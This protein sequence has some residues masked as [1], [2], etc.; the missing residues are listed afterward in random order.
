MSDRYYAFGLTIDSPIRLPEAAAADDGVAVDVMVTIGGSDINVPDDRYFR[1]A[2]EKRSWWQVAP[3]ENRLVFNCPAGLYEIKDGREIRIQPYPDANEETLKIFLLGTAMGAAQI[4]R[5]R[6]PIHGGAI[7]TNRGAMIVTGGQGAGKST[8]TSAF[9]HNGY[10]YL[11]DD[12]SSVDIIDGQALIIPAYP[13]RK[14]V[15]DA[16]GP[17]GYD[18]EE[19]VIVDN[20]RDKFAIRDKD[21]WRREPLKLSLIIELFPVGEGDGVSAQ[22]I[23]GKDKLGHVAKSLYRG[24]MHAPSG[25]LA[26]QEFKKILT[27]AAQADICRVGVPRGI[28]RISDIAGDIASLLDISGE[29]V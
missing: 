23:A 1:E 16:M 19:A 11:T 24:W 27:I 20:A 22:S 29:R 14:L 13:Q 10:R 21:N 8:M 9:V 4:Q 5:G 17:L 28:D 12:V 25:N 2:R 6:M 3:E 15:R 18:P 7:A 26:P